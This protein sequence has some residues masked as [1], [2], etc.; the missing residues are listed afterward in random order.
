[1]AGGGANE[2]LETNHVISGP[3]RGLEI[4]FTSRGIP[5]TYGHCN[6]TTDPA[7][8]AKSVKNKSQEEM[9]AGGLKDGTSTQTDTQA[10]IMTYRL[11]R[12]QDQ[13]SDREE[14][15]LSLNRPLV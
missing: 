9:V 15:K 2:R 8:R 13:F 4:N 1:M 12:P 10:D 5:Q 11:P 3:M 6:Y 7:Q 14:K